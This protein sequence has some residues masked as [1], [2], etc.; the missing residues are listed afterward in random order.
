MCVLLTG[1]QRPTPRVSSTIQIAIY[2]RINRLLLFSCI[3]LIVDELEED[4][5]VAALPATPLYNLAI[6]EDMA[7][8]KQH[9]IL[10]KT[11][12]PSPPL[13]K[14]LVLLKVNLSFF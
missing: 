6:L 7:V 3:L 11:V 13:I 1:L 12:A 8:L 4:R 9:T 2:Q 5:D 10:E 14:A